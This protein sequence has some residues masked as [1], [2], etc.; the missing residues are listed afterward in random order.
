[1]SIILQVG[2]KIFLEKDR[3]KFLLLKHSQKRYPAIKNSWD[4]PCG[5]INEWTTLR[6]NLICEVEEETGLKILGLL[7]NSLAKF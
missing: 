1:M 6:E 2:V 5:R 3:G 7:M 4:I